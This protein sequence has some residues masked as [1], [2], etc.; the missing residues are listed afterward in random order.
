MTHTHIPRQIRHKKLSET[1]RKRKSTAKQIK[2]DSHEETDVKNNPVGHH[3]QEDT[4]L[5]SAGGCWGWLA[6]LARDG[7]SWSKR[8]AIEYRKHVSSRTG[9]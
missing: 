1:K 8:F 9:R 7:R 6:G 4:E 5:Q 3:L 2:L